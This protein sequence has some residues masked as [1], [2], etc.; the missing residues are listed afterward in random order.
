MKIAIFSDTFYPTTNWIVTSVVTFCKELADNWHKIIII[1]PYNKWI[2]NFKYNNIEV[3]AIKWIP[4]IFY[5][6]F[7]ITFWFT[8]N[9]INKIRKFQPELIHFHTQFI[10]GWQW[11][12]M[13]KLLK[14]PT[15]GTFHTY[16][17]D[18]SYLKVMWLNARI[19]WDVGWK[20][21][22]F[23]YKK[24]DKVL[25]PSKNAYNELI[26]HW[27][28]KNNIEILSN[29]LP[30][31][32]LK[33][34]HRTDFLKVVITENIILYVWRLSKEKNINISIEAIYVVSKEIP[35][36]LFVIVWDWPEKANLQKLV[37]KYNLERNVLFLW[38]ISHCD[39]LNSNIFERAKIFLSTSP[40]ENQP[41][42]IIEAMH[43]WLPIV[44]VD[45]KWVGELIEDNWYKAKN[46]N[47]WEIAIYLIR[48]LY[49][50]EL[51][52]Q[53][54]NESR[55]M[56]KNFDSKL[57]AHKLETIYADVI[58]KYNLSKILNNV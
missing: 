5:P 17:A 14:I 27:I 39:L 51:R 24:I 28:D 48:L 38:K 22:N 7:K 41:M 31:I 44:W 45:E 9:L 52:L 57:L 54:W 19:F 36:V 10:T 53:M 16:I 26:K 15:I 49:N 55:A 3:F 32:D 56:M 40:S 43:F 34:E 25:V 21:N 1:T 30:Q 12:I 11:I 23:F 13:W 46:E 47:F 4:A 20:Y 42:T 29:P 8:P 2:E 37:R 6:D 18:E 35:D 33:E 58:A 50:E